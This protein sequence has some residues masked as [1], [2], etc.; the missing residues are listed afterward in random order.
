LRGVPVLPY[1]YP[2][3]QGYKD[4]NQHKL[5]N[6]TR[7][8]DTSD[9]PTLEDGDYELILEPEPGLSEDSV[10]A[11]EEVTEAP[12]Q[13]SEVFNSSDPSFTSEGKPR[14]TSQYFQAITNSVLNY[15]Y[16]ALCPGVEMKP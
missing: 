10:Q 2:R 4:T 14:C 7:I 15:I 5:S 3:G 6:R 16:F 1:I 9:S 11:T 8:C 12:N 13:R